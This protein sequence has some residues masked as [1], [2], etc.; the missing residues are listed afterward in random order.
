[1]ALCFVLFCYPVYSLPIA[2]IPQ[3]SLS[4]VFIPRDPTVLLFVIPSL[5]FLLVL[6]RFKPLCQLFFR[7]R[8]CLSLSLLGSDLSWSHRSQKVPLFSRSLQTSGCLSRSLFIS[9]RP[10]VKVSCLN[11][12]RFFPA[13]FQS[14]ALLSELLWSRHNVIHIPF[15]LTF[16]CLH[17]LLQ[18]LNL[19]HWKRPFS[20]SLPRMHMHPEK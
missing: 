5:R 8:R 3:T 18:L 12:S 19:I 7:S 20:S 11:S 16:Y 1:M 9:L 13:R 14:S 10:Y 4:L 15:V 6:H 2:F 17:S